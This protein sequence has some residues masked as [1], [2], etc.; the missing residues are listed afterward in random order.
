MNVFVTGGSGYIGKA[1]IGTLLR[2]GHTVRALARSERS[3]SAVEALGAAPVHGGLGDLSVLRDASARAE[4]VVHLAQAESGD[5][6]LA[7]ATAMQEGVG[8]GPYVHTGGTWVYGDTDGVVDEDAPWNPPPL[9]AWRRPVEDAV[10]ARA[11]AGGRPVVIRA[12]LL[13]G[14][15]N[16]L[17]DLFYTQPG[18]R[19]GAV[20]HIGDGSAHWALI[21]VDDLAELYAAALRAKPGAVYAG[22]GGVAPTAAQVAAAVSRGAGLGGRTRS[23]TLEQAREEMGGVADAFALDQRFTPARARDELG[24]RPTR[25]DP[26]AVLAEG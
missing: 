20:A 4:A 1:V 26:L 24:W 12:G 18:K 14:G 6:D 9:V 10:L 19:A 21:H 7:A 25:T 13:Y 5:E 22:V 16:R 23:I 2:E 3:A 8:S 11:A 15:A 17:I